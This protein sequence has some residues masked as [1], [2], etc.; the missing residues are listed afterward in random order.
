MLGERLIRLAVD[1]V[2]TIEIIVV[3]YNVNLIKKDIL[4]T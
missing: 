1:E 4:Y 3:R 2:H